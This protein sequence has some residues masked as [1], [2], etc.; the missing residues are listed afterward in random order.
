MLSPV[1]RLAWMLSGLSTKDLSNSSDGVRVQ[2]LNWQYV[3]IPG[4]WN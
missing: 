2:K 1:T 4:K 3:A